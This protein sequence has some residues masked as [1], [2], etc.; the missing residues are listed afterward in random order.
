MLRRAGVCTGAMETPL[1]DRNNLT[2]TSPHILAA[3]GHIVGADGFVVP[4]DV[5][6]FLARYPDALDTFVSRSVPNAMEEE[7][8]ELVLK[9]EGYLQ[10]PSPLT[11]VRTGSQCSPCSHQLHLSPDRFF[12]Y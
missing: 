8:A 5:A 10:S 6:E 11:A 9:L 12:G 3:D 7:R 2:P 4:K 1:I